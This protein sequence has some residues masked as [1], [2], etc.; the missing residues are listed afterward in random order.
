MHYVSRRGTQCSSRASSRKSS[1]ASDASDIS[2]LAGPWLNLPLMMVSGADDVV[3]DIKQQNEEL[4]K[5]IS[6]C[7]SLTY[8]SLLNEMVNNIIC[9]G[10][11]ASDLN[12][13]TNFQDC[14]RV[15]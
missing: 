5:R 1:R 9:S 7:L 11:H 12:L 8:E 2:E 13:L 4:G 10:S 6:S 15:K 14:T 3:R